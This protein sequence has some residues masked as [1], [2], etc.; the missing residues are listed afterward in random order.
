MVRNVQ[1]G[2]EEECDKRKQS[3]KERKSCPPFDIHP[4][5]SLFDPVLPNPT[6][7]AAVFVAFPP[8]NKLTNTKRHVSSLLQL[9]AK[10]IARKTKKQNQI[11]P[12]KRESCSL[13]G[14][15]NKSTR[16]TCH[17]HNQKHP[18]LSCLRVPH[19]PAK[20]RLSL[21]ANSTWE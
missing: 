17:A 16:Y 12:S 6:F 4:W 13:C 1:L 19:K 11:T 9:F 20:E 7:D 18:H 14:T 5:P 8:I 21:R 15:D 3:K 10:Q 2:G